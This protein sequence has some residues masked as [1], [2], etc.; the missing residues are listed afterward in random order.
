MMK[1]IKPAQP[2]RIIIL[3]GLFCFLVCFNI[4]NAQESRQLTQNELNAELRT[5]L[6]QNNEARIVELIKN[7]RLYIK[8][9][10]DALVKESIQLELKG[11]LEEAEKINIMASKAAVI[12][13]EIFDEKSLV[14]AVSYLTTWSKEQKKK[15]LVADSLYAVGTKMRGN[16][17]EKAIGIYNQ[18][19]E[20]YRNIGDERGEAEVLGGFGLI[21]S[22][23]DSQKSWSYYEEALKARENVDDKVLIGNSLN[24]LG[25]IHLLFLNDY[26]QAISYFDK[27]ASVRKEIGD[28]PNLGRSLTAKA[29]AYE[30]LGSFDQALDNYT[31]SYAIY[32]EV[33]DPFR[34]AESLLKSGSML[35]NLG[36]YPEALDQL[37]KSLEIS[38][39]I[40]DGIGI[41]DALNQIGF[42]YLKMGDY[43]TALDKFNEA[44]EITKEQNDQW[45]LAGV[46]NNLAVMLQNAGRTE[47]ALDYYLNALSLYE[48]ENDQHSVLICLL[49]IGT[50]YFDLKDYAKAENYHKRA[51][52]LSRDLLIKDLEANS[53]LNL[54]NDQSITGK[55]DEALSNYTTGYEIAK[56]LNNPDLKWR[57]IAGMAEN[58]ESRNEYDKVVALN[59]TALAILDNLRNTLKRDEFKA[60]FM[61]QERY[62]YE[63]IID[64]LQFLHETNNTKGYDTLAFKYAEQSKS[65]VLLDLLTESDRSNPAG[66]DLRS[67]SLINPEP[68]S[69]TEAK[70]LCPDKNTVILEYSVGDSSSCLWVITQSSHKL[71]RIPDSGTLQE[72]I[73]TIRFALQNPEEK[74]SDF[75]TN[76]GTFLYEKLLKPAEPYLSK[77][78]KLV[79]IPDG[80]LNYLPFEVLLTQNKV[81]LPGNKYSDLP[82]LVKKF[83]VSYGQSASVL[84]S[85]LADQSESTTAAKKLIAFG[86]PVYEDQDGNFEFHYS[87][88][89]FSGKEIENIESYFEKASSEVYVRDKATEQN[90]KKE[91]GLTKFD[92]VHFA[93]HGYIDEDEPDRSSLVLTQEPNTGE[94]GFL[95]A[96][97]IFNLSLN[98]DL[99]V[100]SACQTGLGKLIRG[101]GMVGLTRAFMYAG[102]P[103]IVVSLWSVSDNST[104]VLMGEF[105]KNL[106]KNKLSKTDA[107][108]K[109]QLSLIKDPE[110]AHPFYWAPFILIGDWR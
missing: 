51:L 25:L 105:Y 81:V 106:I 66:T 98:A 59:D 60:S 8:P 33:G 77:K 69:L 80:I 10:V 91:G 56:E 15:K 18:A 94:D 35:I 24:S 21:Y 6:E 93:T 57:F 27:A 62:V 65:R 53:L 86:D 28:L 110:Y 55:K 9:F 103:S 31:R 4:L 37:E 84:R 99:V 44:I 96:S 73:E 101:E 29:T 5:A 45:G 78:S 67:E 88:L 75:F 102:T 14:I 1:I 89:E 58:Y 38:R 40:E 76:A 104:A 63:D 22:S 36:N 23:S 12:F 109:A 97:E 46:Y 49:N 85:L 2:G 50:I 90:V 108:R 17:P 20:I 61:A 52:D 70:L 34:M 43:S 48:K 41:S 79:I 83:P 74:V 71:F 16:E 19:L 13:N 26:Q 11:K 3:S 54:A 42:V 47:K 64:L 107:L 7:H 72:Q 95:R 68:L 32:E 82:F 30:K 87:R 39:D 92:Y 100:L